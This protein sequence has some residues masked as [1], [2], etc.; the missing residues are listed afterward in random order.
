MGFT[1]DDYRKL[2]SRLGQITSQK[3]EEFEV[4]SD[5]PPTL[6]DLPDSNKAYSLFASILFIDIRKSTQL[7][8]ASHAK[9]MVKIYRAFMRMAVSCVRANGG[10]T[11]QF[12]GD[13]IMGVF[14]DSLDDNGNVL[15]SSADKAVEA[16]RAMQTCIDY[17]LNKHLKNH[18]GGKTISC[19]IGIDHGKVLLTKV[20]MYGVEKDDNKEN[21]TDCVW[22]GNC[23]N[24]ASKYSDLADGGEIF[25]SEKVYNKLSSGLKPENVWTSA[26]KHKGNVLFNGYTCRNNYLEFISELGEPVVSIPSGNDDAL[27][28]ATA[29][30]Q[31]GEAWDNISKKEGDLKALEARLNARQEILSEQAE[32]N[33]RFEIVYKIEKS[34][35]RSSQCSFYDMLCGYLQYSFCKSDYMDSMG[36]DFW[37]KLVDEIYSLGKITDKSY[38]EITSQNDCYLIDLYDHFKIYD[39]AYDAMVIMAR[40]NHHWVLIRRNTILWARDQCVV[41]RLRTAIEERIKNYSLECNRENFFKI[42]DEIKDIVGY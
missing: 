22:V 40:K 25:I 10:V 8:E 42:L 9:S 31:I 15:I 27:N 32:N 21:E 34:E 1:I 12:L 19:G 37:R 30:K 20:G 41:W 13:R 23:T 18:V 28:L 3:V 16:A 4:S 36:Y 5:T 24:R 33:R 7:T 39:K 14:L 35:L 38:E 6:D 26:A 29:I 17:T 2:D 11:R